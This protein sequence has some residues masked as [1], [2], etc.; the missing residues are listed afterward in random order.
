MQKE[1]QLYRT[2]SEFLKEKYGEKVYKLPINLPLTCPNRDGKVG[3]GGCTFCA[4]VGTGFECLP[5]SYE[6][7]EQLEKNKSYIQKKYKANKFIAYF[8]NFSNT[9]MPFEQ[10][11]KYIEEAI[12]EDVVEI[13]ISTRPDCINDKYLGFLQSLQEKHHIEFSIELGLQTVNYHTLN[14][15]NRGHTLAEFIDAVLRIKRYGF[16]ICAHLILNLPWDTETDVIENAKIM[17]ALGIEQVKLHGLYIM[18]NTAMGKM[19]ENKE[20]QMI[21]VEE[22]QERVMIFLEYLS[23]H[24]V[25]QRL[26]GRAPKENSLFVN[27]NMS[28]WKIRDEIHEMMIQNHRYQGKKSDYLNGKALD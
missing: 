13:A 8:Q 26:I 14:K 6:V 7:V 28:W 15:I 19:Y 22:Y 2:Y 17:S 20:F 21:S 12:V 11:Q 18:E 9:Y 1:K 4:E 10:F 24:I 23:S 16:P 25:V 5:N 27:W 3:I